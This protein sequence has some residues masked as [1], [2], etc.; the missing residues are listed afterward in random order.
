MFGRSAVTQADEGVAWAAQVANQGTSQRGVGVAELTHSVLRSQFS[1]Y[2]DGSLDSSDRRRVERHLDECR[3]CSAY[4]D[5]M[6]KT[7]ELLGELP[8]KAAP[9]GA[10]EAILKRARSAD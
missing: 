1:D 10:K 9:R 4:L 7:A 8:P 6:R 5:T 3:A 2:L